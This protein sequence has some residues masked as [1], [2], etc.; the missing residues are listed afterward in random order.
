MIELFIACCAVA[1][2]VAAG[3]NVFFGIT[4]FQDP[5]YCAEHL[6]ESDNALAVLVVCVIA[7]SILVVLL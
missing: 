6:E 4:S 2:A 7:G 5:G 3:Y 1:A